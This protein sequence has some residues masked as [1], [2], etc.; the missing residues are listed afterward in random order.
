MK[1]LTALIVVSLLASGAWARSIG[2][3]P[4]AGSNTGKGFDFT[5]LDVDIGNAAFELVTQD[6]GFTQIV[7]PGRIGV[8]FS[9]SPSSSDT[10]EVKITG[11]R[12]YAGAQFSDS[13][14]HWTEQIRVAGLDT[15][16]T[17][18]SYQYFEH[19]WLDTA[20]ANPI[21][22]FSDLTTIR[23]SIL[24]TIAIGLISQPRAHVIFGAH[25]RPQLDRITFTTFS[26]TGTQGIRFEV[27]VY[28]NIRAAIDYTTKYYVIDYLYVRAE[29]GETVAD[30]SNMIIP[31]GSAIAV[32]ARADADNM[33]GKVRMV[34]RRQGR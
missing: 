3:N 10:A 24:D 7:T 12:A 23:N 19:A 32:M 4:F 1:R 29:V 26:T 15:V 27:R 34:G 9:G 14:R 16:R 21:V 30:Y 11:V 22:V 25:E 18:S 8:T 31:A 13:L 17:D 6:T 5:T 33:T 20:M 2:T 28:P